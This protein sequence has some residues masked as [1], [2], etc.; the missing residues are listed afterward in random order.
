MFDIH[1]WVFGD[2][3]VITRYKKQVK[4]KGENVEGKYE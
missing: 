3:T 4:I 1:I 2:Y